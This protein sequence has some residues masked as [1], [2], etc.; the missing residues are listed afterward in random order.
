[1]PRCLIVG[2]GARGRELAAALRDRGHVIRATTRDERKLGLIEATGA[3]AVLADPDRLA[4]LASALDH[5]AVLVLLL[6]SAA[7]PPAAVEALHRERLDALLRRL[8]DT[9]VRGVVYEAAGSLD[10]GLLAA[11]GRIV[12]DACERGRIPYALVAT[13]PGPGW[14]EAMVGAVDRVLP[15]SGAPASWRG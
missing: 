14:L 15:A 11:G 13:G 10:A 6:G 2:C 7:G 9:T 12:R 1:M 3:E 8:L 5:V 4:T